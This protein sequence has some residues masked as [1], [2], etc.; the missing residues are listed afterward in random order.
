MQQ[1]SHVTWPFAHA[2]AQGMIVPTAASRR[3]KKD[4]R[5]DH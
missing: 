5:A 2:S 4:E 1:S 3:S